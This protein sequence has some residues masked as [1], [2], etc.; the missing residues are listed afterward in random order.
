MFSQNARFPRSL[1]LVFAMTLAIVLLPGAVSGQ[2]VTGTLQ[3]TVTDANGAIVP[4]ADI[5]VRNV[6]TGQERNLKT[7]NDGFYTASFLPLG[8]YTIKAS[9][10]SLKKT[11]RS[12]LMRRAL[13][14][15]LSARL[16]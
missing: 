5:V 6:E 13:S 11:S 3:G 4:G 10:Q 12:L 8:R 9:A 16:L 7:N 15:L 2:T 14:I 1:F